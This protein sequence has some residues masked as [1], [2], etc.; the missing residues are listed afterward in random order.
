MDSVAGYAIHRL[1]LTRS[2]NLTRSMR[3]STVLIP[4]TQISP[5]RCH[6]NPI[7]TL[8][9]YLPSHRHRILCAVL[10]ANCLSPVMAHLKRLQAS[11]ATRTASRLIDSRRLFASLAHTA[12]N[13]T[14][15]RTAFHLGGMASVF[16]GMGNPRSGPAY[17]SLRRNY[18]ARPPPKAA[19]CLTTF[20]I[21]EVV[22]DV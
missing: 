7:T 4:Y 20:V 3:T 15:D 2:K 6:R 12:R 17:R 22:R 21:L 8:Y 9:T 13:Q 14:T 16:V 19:C 18:I 1:W 10:I 11:D 5:D